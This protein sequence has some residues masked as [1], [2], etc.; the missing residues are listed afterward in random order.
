MTGLL[1][2]S[3]TRAKKIWAAI[4][5]ISML[6]WAWGV[7]VSLL[8]PQLG[9]LEKAYAATSASTPASGLTGI[10][11]DKT[12]AGGSSTYTN[13]CLLYTSDAADE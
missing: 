10:S 13:A 4:G 11:L 1:H 5:L 6:Q 2:A 7:P 12:T 9:Q 8:L 3:H